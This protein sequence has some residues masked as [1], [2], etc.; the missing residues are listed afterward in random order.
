M[1]LKNEKTGVDSKLGERH[2]I[3][4]IFQVG[5]EAHTAS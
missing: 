1:E 2:F 3:L 4:Q 5:S